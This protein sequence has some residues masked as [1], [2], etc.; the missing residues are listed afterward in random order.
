[1][2]TGPTG[3]GGR[4][5]VAEPSGRNRSRT[6]NRRELV[7]WGALVLAIGIVVVFLAA[8]KSSTTVS[9]KTSPVGRNY[10]EGAAGELSGA[11]LPTV[12]EM[13]RRVAADQV[14]VL[15]GAVARWDTAL[16]EDMIRGTDERILVAPPGLTDV[17]QKDLARVESATIR[18][19]G[20][21]VSGISSSTLPEWQHQFITRDITFLLVARIAID[22]DSPTPSVVG[23][24]EWRP[25]TTAELAPVVRELNTGTDLFVAPGATLTKIPADAEHAFPPGRVLYAAFP[26]QPRGEPVPDFGTALTAAFPGTPI[27]VMYGSWVGY[28]GPGQADFADV[29]AAGYFGPYGDRLGR[30]EYPQL[31]VLGTYLDQMTNMRYAGVYDLPLPYRPVDPLA[32][33][34]PALPWVFGL[35]VVVFLALSV[36][37]LVQGRTAAARPGGGTGSAARLAGLTSL[38][39]EM[40][41]L[42]GSAGNPSLTRGIRRLQSATEALAGN[43]PVR[44]VKLQLDR[45]ETELAA[46]ARALGRPDYQPSAYLAGLSR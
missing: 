44:Q 35:C 40:S 18:V 21:D 11:V 26:Y 43:L 20:T 2:P 46:T 32:L 45:A 22:Q 27:V 28:Y 13:E 19:V 5:H 30:F 16:I 9:Y 14:V 41:A 1:M 29:V 7:R 24:V 37:P 15:D 8:Q 4:P 34:L 10:V 38:A 39:V 31:N 23:P 33:A 6:L 17:Q 42:T 3:C 25:P 12:E 36:T